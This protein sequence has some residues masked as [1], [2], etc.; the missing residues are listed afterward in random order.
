MVIRRGGA[1]CEGTSTLVQISEATVRVLLDAAPDAILVTDTNGL[2]VLANAQV[3]RL[4]GYT[5]DELLGQTVELLLPDAVR[6]LHPMHRESYAHDPRARAM[7]LG[8]N[9]A[10]R[11]KDGT[12][13]PAEVSLSATQASEGLLVSAAVRDVTQRLEEDGDRRRMAERERDR[14]EA[15]LN[16]SRRLESLG[17]L[18]GGVAH[19]F[20]NLLAVIL[21]Y[22]NFASE[23]IGEARLGKLT[24]EGFDGLLGDI[25]EIERAA[26]RA[27]RLTRQLLAFGRREMIHPEVLDLN[28]VVDDMDRLLQRTLGEQVRF[29]AT[30][31]PDLL[32][33]EAD[34]GQIEQVLVNLAVNARDAMPKGGTLS[35]DTENFAVDQDYADRHPGLLAGP[36]VRLRVSDTGAGMPPE[37]LA[38]AFEPFFTTKAKGDGSGLGLATVYGIVAQA[39]GA[40]QLYSE[41]GVG[42]TVSILLPAVQTDIAPA[43]NPDVPEARS[44][45]ETI[46][47]VEDE[48][49]I[50]ELA[51]RILERHGFQVL[52]AEHGREAIDLAHDYAGPIDLLLSDVIMPGMGGKE[53][54]ERLSSTLGS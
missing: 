29:V 14:L 9:V 4:F 16:Q 46:L 30:H 42:T 40:V 10:A 5:R 35:F 34:R 38:R 44:G 25:G 27:A 50:R 51:R 1:A 31:A 32:R 49:A 36:H 53:V 21:N 37:V 12:E 15:Q 19:D 18:A 6:A 13:F 48:A 20:N 7:G 2:I 17:Q 22:A 41:P 54:A 8:L 26:E 23:T 3:E 39:G 11:R 33:I 24:S 45:G 28:A 47:V 43:A 52:I